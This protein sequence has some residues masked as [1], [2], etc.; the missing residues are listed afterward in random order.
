ME[1]AALRGKPPHEVSTDDWDQ[2]TASL[3]GILRTRS[4]ELAKDASKDHR[5]D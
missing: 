4:F 5:P 3:T 1:L 2:A